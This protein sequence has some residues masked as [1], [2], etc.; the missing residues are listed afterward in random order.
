MVR[1]Q[2]QLTERQ[3]HALRQRSSATG[4]SIADLIRQ[5]VE[6]YVGPEQRPNRE[7]QIERALRVAG[8]FSSGSAGGSQEHDRHLAE[9]WRR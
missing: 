1:T 3:L 9:A 8:K 7:E 5:G 6:L 2:V 4:R